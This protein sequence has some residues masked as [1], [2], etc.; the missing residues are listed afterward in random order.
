MKKTLLFFCV[1]L[2]LTNY[3]GYAQRK[4]GIVQVKNALIAKDA[5]WQNKIEA[6]RSSLQSMADNYLQQKASGAAKTTAASPIPVI[7]HIV[8]TAD[9]LTQMG[10][11]TGVQTRCDSQIAVLNCDFNRENSDSTII[12]SGW[13]PLYASVGIRF[14]LAH[15]QPNGWSTPGYEVIIISNSD[16]GFMPG[17]D[18]Y[19]SDVKH[20][21]KG[22]IDAWDVTKYLNVWCFNFADGGNLGLTLAKSMASGATANEE[23]ISLTWLALGKQ[24]IAGDLKFPSGGKFIRGRTLTHEMGHFFEI[25]HTWGDDF[26]KCAWNGGVDDGIADTPPEADHKYGIPTDTIPG[27]TI[28]DDCILNGTAPMQPIGVASLDFMNYTD[29]V[30]MAMFTTQQAAA[31]AAHVAPSGESYSLT[32]NPGLLNWPANAG[33]APVG[34]DNGLNIFPNPSDGIFNITFNDI[35]DELKNINVVDVVGQQVQ[36]II[37]VHAQKDYSIDLSGMSKGI[38]F[39]R[40]N[41]ASG[42]ITRKILLQ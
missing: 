11:Y 14:G 33:V 3:N 16:N 2:L 13:K 1:V 37:P 21:A 35:T 30:A 26:G 27:G 39:V 5:N 24:T 12:P 15:T 9:Q 42:S 19:Y 31:M 40:C 32:Q 34:M 6:Q 25:W 10:G 38:Y 23:G 36:S 4:C 29:D 17:S 28:Y 18:G 7:F 41:F 8:V 20:T 22:G